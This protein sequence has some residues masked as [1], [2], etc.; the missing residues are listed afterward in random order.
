MTTPPTSDSSPTSTRRPEGGSAQRDTWKDRTLASVSVL[1]SAVGLIAGVQQLMDKVSTVAI[2]V[3]VGALAVALVTAGGYVY[4]KKLRDNLSRSVPLGWTLLTGTAVVALAVVTSVLLT[5]R[6]DDGDTLPTP[7]PTALP[8]RTTVSAAPSDS[9][10][11]SDSASPSGPAP[12]ACTTL[13]TAAKIDRG[14][15]DT[16]TGVRLSSA[17]YSVSPGDTPTLRW[18][19]QITGRP[20]AGQVL[21]FAGTADPGTFD[22]TDK[23]NPGSRFFLLKGRLNADDD[24]CW[25]AGPSAVYDCAG[26]VTF[27]AHV[28]LMS[29]QQAVK[30][31]TMNKNEYIHDNGVDPDEFRSMPITFLD[32][33]DIPTKP[34]P[35][36]P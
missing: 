21:Y 23:H 33:F 30:L 34:G 17:S 4:R 14:P 26:G 16:G 11:P 31:D 25:T 32:S 8:S 27:I 7:G 6:Q 12:A 2:S 18:A 29:E 13:Q 35:G 3:L 24:G 19:G 10:S 20:G 1:S 5:T 28:L 15:G 22:G 9:I 36:C